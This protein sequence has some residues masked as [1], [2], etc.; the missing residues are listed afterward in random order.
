MMLGETLGVA[1]R[2]YIVISSLM[3]SLLFRYSKFRTSRTTLKWD[4]TDTIEDWQGISQRYLVKNRIFTVQRDLLNG[5]RSS[6]V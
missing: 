4:Y 1:V 2:R 5:T 3:N 6:T